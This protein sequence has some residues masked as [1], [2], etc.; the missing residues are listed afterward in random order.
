MR[1]K[2]CSRFLCIDVHLLLFL[3]VQLVLNVFHVDNVH[4]FC[5]IHRISNVDNRRWFLLLLDLISLVRID[6]TV[7]RNPLWNIFELA[8]ELDRF[9]VFISFVRD[10]SCLLHA[11][12]G[13]KSALLVISIHLD[14]SKAGFLND[15]CNRLLFLSLFSPLLR[16]FGISFNFPRQWWIDPATARLQNVACRGFLGVHEVSAGAILFSWR[17]ITETVFS[18]CNLVDFILGAG[19]GRDFLGV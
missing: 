3:L 13:V 15:F 16:N 1:A 5:C 6:W 12:L 10:M 19:T 8:D 17:R 14:F 4:L 11:Y 2:E 9:Q 7:S 18:C